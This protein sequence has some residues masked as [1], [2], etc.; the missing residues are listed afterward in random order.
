MPEGWLP[1]RAP[2][3]QPPPHFDMVVPILNDFMDLALKI[4][5]LISAY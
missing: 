5:R 4:P 1:P 2:G 3:G